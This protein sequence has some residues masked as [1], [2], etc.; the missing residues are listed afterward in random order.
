MW[1]PLITT[2]LHLKIKNLLSSAS[3]RMKM[4]KN[5]FVTKWGDFSWPG[6]MGKTCDYQRSIPL[7][8]PFLSLSW[9]E[10]VFI[11]RKKNRTSIWYYDFLQ[12]QPAREI[13]II[14][15]CIPWIQSH[16]KKQKN[17]LKVRQWGIYET[18]YV[19]YSQLKH[20]IAP[21]PNLTFQMSTIRSFQTIRIGN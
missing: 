9:I 20:S 3:I 15:V 10:G 19:L 6:K 12:R 17:G 14:R 16:V 4:W 11:F 21:I 13:Y 8:P 18:F 7:I 1:F 5:W 2:S